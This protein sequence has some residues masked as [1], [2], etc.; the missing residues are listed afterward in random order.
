MAMIN[1]SG[2]RARGRLALSDI[3]LWDEADRE[4]LYKVLDR[5]AF[6]TDASPYRIRFHLDKILHI[7]EGDLFGFPTFRL[8]KLLRDHSFLYSSPHPLPDMRSFE[9]LYTQHNYKTDVEKDY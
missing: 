1:I 9:Y 5:P 2:L 8:E 7:L 3:P 6:D 4:F